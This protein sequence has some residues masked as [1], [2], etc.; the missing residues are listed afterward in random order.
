MSLMSSTSGI[1]NLQADSK[2]DKY[3][4]IYDA[5]CSLCRH[6]IGVIRR[7]D[8]FAIFEYMPSQSEGLAERFPVLQ[9]ENFSTG[10]RLLSPENSVFTGP[11]AVYEVFRRLPYWRWLAWM[12]RLPGIHFLACQIY[13]YIALNREKLGVRLFDNPADHAE[14]D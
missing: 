4:V 12:Y 1:S 6:Q 9:A 11:D 2:R 10:L 5:N 3:I 7:R 13:R 8:K 14:E